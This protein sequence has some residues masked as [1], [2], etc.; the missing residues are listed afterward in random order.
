MPTE[1]PDLQAVL[2]DLDDTLNDRQQSWMAFV[3]RMADPLIGHLAPC[4]AADVHRM[5]VL[6]DEGGYRNKDLLFG[7]MSRLPWKSPKSAAD[8]EI[9]WREH[10]PSCMVTRSGVLAVLRRLR[11]LNVRTGIVTNGRADNQSAKLIK[12]GLRDAVDVVIISG[13]VGFKKP[14]PRIYEAA[15][16]E[17]NVA[18]SDTLFVGDNPQ[19]DVVGPAK[20]G[21]RTAWLSNGRDWLFPDAKPEYTL[22]SFTELGPVLSKLHRRWA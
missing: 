2:F 3:E 11:E 20:A 6:A 17:L 13:A 9:L 1:Q 4:V 21:M 18:A 10:F 7:D 16:S 5:I 19:S 22:K 15:V 8:V 12:M 14:D